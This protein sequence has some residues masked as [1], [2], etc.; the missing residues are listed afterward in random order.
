MRTTRLVMYTY[1]GDANLDG[2]I[3]ADDYFQ[4]DS[5]YNQNGNNAAISFHDGDFNY[6]GKIDGQDYFLIDQAFAD[7]GSIA[8]SPPLGGGLA[9][10]SAVPEPASIMGLVVMGGRAER[11][12][13][14]RR[15]TR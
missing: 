11:M 14:E 4:I 5:N 3:N 6:D 2:K 8:L 15:R 12:R 10:V 9:G 13:R 1:A 7:Q